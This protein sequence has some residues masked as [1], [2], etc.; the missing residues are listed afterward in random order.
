MDEK[1]HFCST[2][3]SMKKEMPKTKT[4]TQLA[5][6]REWKCVFLKFENFLNGKFFSFVVLVEI[7]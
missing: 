1:K 6:T 7:R 3:K 4:D 2:E 5:V